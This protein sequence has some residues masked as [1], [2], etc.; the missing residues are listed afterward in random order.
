[1]HGATFDEP[2]ATATTLGVTPD[3]PRFAFVDLE[4]VDR[5]DLSCD[6]GDK[7]EHSYLTLGV[8]ADGVGVEVENIGQVPTRSAKRSGAT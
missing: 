4:I 7:A 3:R 8:R 5:T 6:P 2:S 1:M